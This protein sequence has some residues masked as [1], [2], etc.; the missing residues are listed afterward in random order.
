MIKLKNI[1]LEKKELNPKQIQA[2]GVLTQRNEHNVSRALVAKDLLKNMLKGLRMHHLADGKINEA[3]ETIFD[4]A[5]RVM[6][7]SQNY[8]YKSKKG[9]VKVDMQSA[10]LLVK[11][12]KKVNPKMKQIL[13][14]LG[15][16]NPAGLMK[17]LWAVVK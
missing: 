7:D 10:N 2:I 15:D 4:V 1:L 16:D 12:F 6:K 17:T 11:V 14:K 13:S 9:M 8:N 5:A 3:K